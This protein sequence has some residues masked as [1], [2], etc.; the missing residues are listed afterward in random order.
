[1]GVDG[2]GR[3]AIGHVHD[4][5]RRLAAHAR[6]ILKLGVGVRHLAAVP[7]DQEV[8]ER[9]HVLG[10]GAEEADRLDVVDQFFLAQCHHLGRGFDLLE[11]GLGGSVHAGVGG[12]GRQHDGDQELVDVVVFEFG[13]RLGDRLP[14]AGEKLGDDGGLHQGHIAS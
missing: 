13:F 12:L 6:Q 11:Q 10:L 1:M 3:L 14:Q 7:L 8:A 9:D 4:D 2:D 5:V